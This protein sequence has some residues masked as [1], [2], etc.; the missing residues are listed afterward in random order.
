[1]LLKDFASSTAN[2]MRANRPDI[3]A[4][5]QPDWVGIIRQAGKD[6]REGK[7]LQADNALT[8][9]LIAE[10]PEKEAEI[11]QM[12]GRAYADVLK[13]DAQRAEDRQWRLEDLQAQR[14][15]QKEL[16]DL[17]T[18]RAFALENMR[19]A[20]ARSLAE[21][22]ASLNNNSY[23]TSVNGYDLTGNKAYDDAY[24]K[25]QGKK[26]AE[27]AIAMR[28][29]KD[30]EPA[31]RD[32]M[33]QGYKAASSGTGTGP[34]GGRLADWGLNIMPNA[35]RNFADIST[36]NNQM[37][38]YLRKQ[39]AATGLTGQ[40]LNSAVEAEAYR[41]NISPRDSEAIVKRKMENFAK[42]KLGGADFLTNAFTPNG[43]NAQL[44][45]DKY[46][47]E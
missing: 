2:I 37:N 1:M 45:K 8:E 33:M 5:V 24:L 17:Q 22:K 41:Y 10:N 6:Y 27:T 26:D 19:N 14:D 18:Q 28:D 9:Q 12:G 25:A 29:A 36:A 15:F 43:I 20:N 42:D 44:Y 47:L 39:L 40:E 16:I 23:P 3:T 21:F 11:R 7:Q 38:A 32:S 31:L 4:P 34:I 30:M 46:G 13:A 35:G